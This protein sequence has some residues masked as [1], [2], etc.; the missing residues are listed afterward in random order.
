MYAKLL[1]N[2]NTLSQAEVIRAL[3]IRK[4]FN[5]EDV[6]LMCMFTTLIITAILAT[7]VLYLLN[8]L[9][10]R[11]I[12]LWARLSVLGIYVVLQIIIALKLREP[13]QALEATGNS[14]HQWNL[15]RI[16]YLCDG[17]I[18][19]AAHM[20]DTS[21]EMLNIVLF[22]IIQ[23]SIIILLVIIIFI[24]QHKQLRHESL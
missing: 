5:A 10:A 4:I 21:Y 13:F 14:P 17:M 24:Y 1:D 16:F 6:A 19:V 9:K 18:I 2:P 8:E 23:P 11:K 22:A 3:E 7:V 12:K 20:A 15:H